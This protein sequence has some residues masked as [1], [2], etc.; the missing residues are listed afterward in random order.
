M[1]NRTPEQ[2]DLLEELLRI[3]DDQTRFKAMEMLRPAERRA[4]K[5]VWELWSRL[6]LIHI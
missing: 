4:F 3:K 2:E 1:A 5:H 6:S